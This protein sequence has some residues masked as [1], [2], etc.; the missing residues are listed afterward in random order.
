MV[1]ERKGCVLTLTRL[2]STELNVS[3]I[4]LLKSEPALSLLFAD[5]EYRVDVGAIVPT[6]AQLEKLDDF[7]NPEFRA[8]KQYVELAQTVRLSITVEHRYCTAHLQ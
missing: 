7:A 2:F 4:P 3:E 1:R 6:D 8:K 5:T